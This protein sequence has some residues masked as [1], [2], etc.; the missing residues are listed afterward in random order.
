LEGRAEEKDQ[1][2]LGN[3]APTATATPERPHNH[4]EFRGRTEG[5][6]GRSKT[7]GNQEWENN[8]ET[9]TTLTSRSTASLAARWRFEKG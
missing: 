6:R 8:P 2:P 9:Y 3:S 4:E 1:A 5:R 7:R